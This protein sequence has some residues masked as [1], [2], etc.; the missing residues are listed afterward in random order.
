MSEHAA[1]TLVRVD[2]SLREVGMHRT[3]HPIRIALVPP[4]DVIERSLADSS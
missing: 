1:P 3:L 4:F 2:D